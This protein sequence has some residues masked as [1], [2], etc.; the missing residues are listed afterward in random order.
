MMGNLSTLLA[1]LG[2]LWPR[3]ARELTDEVASGLYMSQS[4]YNLKTAA[5]AEELRLA[6]VRRDGRDASRRSTS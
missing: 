5:I 4:L 2:D 1:E 3:C 6:R